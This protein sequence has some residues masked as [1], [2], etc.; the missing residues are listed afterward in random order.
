MV[1]MVG[2][3]FR[4]LMGEADGGALARRVGGEGRVKA[5]A[6]N[7]LHSSAQALACARRGQG[8]GGG[9]RA[10]R[11]EGGAREVEDGRV[12]ARSCIRRVQKKYVIGFNR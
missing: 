12:H 11:K 9:V 5:D 3:R 4:A 1:G 6:T 2:G 10:R 7:A 8:V